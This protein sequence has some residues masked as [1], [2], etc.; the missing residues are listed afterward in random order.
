MIYRR[1]F[2]LAA[3]LSI[4]SGCSGGL[5]GGGPDCGSDE[6]QRLIDQVVKE[7][8]EF[9]IQSDLDSQKELGSYDATQLDNAISRIKLRLEDVRTSRDDP[10][11]SRL[12]C[13]ASLMIDL[14][15]A[16]ES[17]ANEA[18][19]LAEAD[20]VREIANR[21]KIKRRSGKYAVEFDY[22]VQPTDDG[23][24]LFA[25]IDDDSAALDFMGEV[26]GSY[27][28]ADEIRD[29]KIEADKAEA[30]A[31]RIE[32]EAIEAEEAI[33]RE[34]EEAF[35]AE[36]TAALKAAEVERK[37]ASDS[38]NAVWNAMPPGAKRDIEKLHDAWVGQMKARCAAQ[39]AGTD[40]RA[41]MRKARELNCQT[42][43]VRSCANSLQRNLESPSRWTYCVIR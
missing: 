17:T 33:E 12:A 24:K 15:K 4:V 26:L 25:E 6:A 5:L 38:I 35:N 7:E 28:L 3:A 19:A 23:D 39:A 29:Q 41:S 27:L 32:R 30:E 13:R 10:D 1:F 16:V 2:G 9:A 20:T 40:Q 11:S 37:L 21:Y 43:L 36:G 22:F 8:L 42:N 18:L 31:K 34:A 14:P